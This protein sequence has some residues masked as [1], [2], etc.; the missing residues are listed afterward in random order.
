[1]RRSSLL[2]MC[3]LLPAALLLGAAIACDER[4]TLG[5]DPV[6]G[7]SAS[8]A[9]S[10][11]SSFAASESQIQVTW[12]DNSP[13][14][15]GFEVHRSITGADGQFARVASTGPAVTSYSD[16]GL[17]PSTEYC[18][19]VRAVRTTARAS[20]Y[21]EFSAPTCATTF[22]PPA[23]N[24]PLGIEARPTSSS[25]VEVRWIDNAN[26]EQGFRLERSLDAGATWSTVATVGSYT[27]SSWDY[28]LTS[29]VP[30]CYR[31]FAFNDVGDSPASN[32]DCTT[33]PTA[34]TD[35]TATAAADPAIQLAWTDQSAVE[36]GYQIERG[37][38]GQGMI[39]LAVLPA[40]ST[41]FRDASV[42]S[43]KRY[44][45]VIR[46][47][48]DGGI[49]GYTTA[50]AVIAS[51]PPPAPGPTQARPN[52]SNSVVV[53][54]EWQTSQS[55][56]GFRV[57]RSTDHEAN[58]A[59]IGSSP[60][61]QPGFFD[62]T[63]VSEQEFCYRAFAF[64]DKGE[65]G[66]STA[67]CTVP[68]A[69]PTALTATAIADDPAGPAID[70]TWTDNSQIEDGY[71]VWRLYDC[72]DYYDYCSPYWAQIATLAPNTTSY[73]D[74]GLIAGQTYSYIVIARKDGGYSDPAEITATT[75]P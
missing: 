11:A 3:R 63:V 5:L 62:G 38:D 8:A 29:D 68:L 44:S 50:S 47:T 48:K 69:A 52:T 51:G 43:D 54:W 6:V 57:E 39:V 10:N 35:L 21:S 75:E 53:S 24:A 13:N 26:N 27:L 64:N 45:Y 73:R 70:L 18:Y 14:E 40:N 59:T 41:S 17:T 46:A 30:V 20:T 19:K 49:S 56:E 32:V 37:Q 61:N 15:S 36:D 31:V 7:F 71:E 67:A 58:W 42:V 33:P 60:W 25:T 23:P 1:M 22:A 16:E 28:D 4:E 72:Y 34:P 12:Q 2:P 66:P 74:T 9:P 65:S 55:Q